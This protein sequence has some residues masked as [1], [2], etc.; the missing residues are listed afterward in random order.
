VKAVHQ[1]YTLILVTDE[2][3]PVRRMHVSRKS[4]R[5]GAGAVLAAGLV[6]AI[7]LV[8]YV[9]LRRDSAD[10]LALREEAKRHRGELSALGAEVGGIASELERLRE[11]ERKVRVI[12][13][14][15][16]AMREA[17]VPDQAGQGG[18]EELLPAAE[19]PAE[20]PAQAGEES[21]D[22]LGAVATSDGMD[23]G[24]LAR[25]QSRARLL[26]AQ[27]PTRKLSLLDLIEGLEGQSQR[28]AA[29]PSIWP[30]NG[31]VTSGYGKR[32]S[33]FTGRSQFHS[34]L[35]IAADF[36][37]TVVAPARGRVIFSGTNGALG[38][39]VELDHGYGLRTHFAHLAKAYVKQGQTVERG[40]PIG[41]VGS[42]GRSTGPHLHYGVEANGR[43]V[44]PTNYIFE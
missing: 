7:G 19:A 17:R 24:A 6:L 10:V 14:L 43:T 35:D 13:N 18:G 26:G 1:R 44:D 5:R 39:M 22:D 23:S 21:S 20:A 11:L 12:A 2:L 40:V 41:A 37:T 30:T 28:L 42:T 25:L 9:R 31:Y 36:G 38:R 32:V 4:L 15:P 29:T 16:V 8:D 27:V 3:S 34:G 33:P